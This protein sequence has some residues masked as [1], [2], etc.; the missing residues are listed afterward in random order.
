MDLISEYGF[1]YNRGEYE[2]YS[3][4]RQFR[5]QVW[6]TN[7]GPTLGYMKWHVQKWE[8]ELEHWHTIDKGYWPQSPDNALR[9]ANHA[10]ERA[11]REEK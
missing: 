2:A 5:A 8:P 1:T 10:L 7:K 6:E 11:Y 9:D 4:D 3:E